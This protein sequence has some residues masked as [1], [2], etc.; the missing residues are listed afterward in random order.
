MT[1][2]VAVNH[3]SAVWT[4]DR[5]VEYLLLGGLLTEAVWFV[6]QLGDWKTQIMLSGIIHCH[7]ENTASGK[8]RSVIPIAAFTF[9]CPL[10]SVFL[11]YGDMGTGPL[12]R[13]SAIPKVRVRVRVSVIR[14]RVRVSRSKVSRVRVSG[15]S[16]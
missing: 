6:G 16:E 14:F 15:P 13:R 1:S 9:S 8:P 7:C 5:A 10:P 2:A 3:L 4:P 11:H 12:F